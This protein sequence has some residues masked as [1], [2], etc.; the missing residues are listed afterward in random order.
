[1]TDNESPSQPA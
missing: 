1:M